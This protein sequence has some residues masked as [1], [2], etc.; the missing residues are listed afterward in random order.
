MS[1]TLQQNYFD[2][3]T[4][5]NETDAEMQLLL[6]VIAM[7]ANIEQQIQSFKSSIPQI[8]DDIVSKILSKM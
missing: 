6:D 7:E 8:E 1:I 4:L 3:I 5:N 2:N